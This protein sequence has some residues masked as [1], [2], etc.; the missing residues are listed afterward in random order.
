MLRSRTL[1]ALRY[2]FAAQLA[3]DG[4]PFGGFAQSETRSLNIACAVQFRLVKNVFAA[5]IKLIKGDEKIRKNTYWI[6]KWSQCARFEITAIQCWAVMAAHF[7]LRNPLT[8]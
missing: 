8:Y 3:G 6:V 7:F 5:A 4:R 2:T 1:S